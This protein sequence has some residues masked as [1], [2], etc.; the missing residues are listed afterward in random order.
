[1]SQQ[2]I[3]KAVEEMLEGIQKNPRSG[4]LNYKANVTWEGDVLFSSKVA[5]L[6][7]LKI[8][9]PPAFGGGNSAQSPADL[10]LSALGACQGI[11]YSALASYMDIQLDHLE[12]KLSGD[13][14]LRGLL[15]LGQEQN[16]PPGFQNIKF[17][18]KIK[19]PASQERLREL[20][21]AVESQ[22]P[23]LDTL[24]RSVNV[25]GKAVLN[26][27]EYVAQ[28]NLKAHAA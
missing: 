24:L 25:R 15:G 18:T 13:L 2:T 7:A 23:I 1:M 16:I 11:M 12:I 27:T 4:L 14:D 19:S 10:I 6:P 20:V 26:D 21:E 9:E 17:E 3:K 28:A 22:C 5:G 8:D